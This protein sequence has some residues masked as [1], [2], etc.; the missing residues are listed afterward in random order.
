MA[1]KSLPPLRGVGNLKR[2]TDF[3]ADNVSESI[4]AAHISAFLMVVTMGGECT[5]K[6]LAKAYNKSQSTTYYHIQVLG[7]GYVVTG[8]VTKGYGLVEATADPT[9]SRRKI[10]RY[11]PKGRSVASAIFNILADNSNTGE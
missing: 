4:T 3:L 1:D 6:D 2:V 10:I 9:D 8:R 5:I 11:T 7:E